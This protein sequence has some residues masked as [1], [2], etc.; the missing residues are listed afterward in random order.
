MQVNFIVTLYCCISENLRL[1]FR[2]PIVEKT[3][4]LKK[5][6]V[7]VPE[8]EDFLNTSVGKS[9]VTTQCDE[10]DQEPVSYHE[11]KP[12]ITKSIFKAFGPFFLFATFCKLCH[13][14][15]LFVSPWLLG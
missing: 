12:S 9:S 14:C 1:F 7:K 5:R 13:D 10:N 15:L 11:Y 6:N 8:K 3:V 4:K 2:S